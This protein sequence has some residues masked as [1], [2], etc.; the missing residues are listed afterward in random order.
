MVWVCYEGN[1]ARPKP[2][3]FHIWPIGWTIS[4]PY[5]VHICPILFGFLEYLQILFIFLEK[6]NI[7]HLIWVK[8][9]ESTSYYT[10][11]KV[12]FYYNNR[13]IHT[14]MNVTIFKIIKYTVHQAVYFIDLKIYNN[15]IHGG[16]TFCRKTLCRKT[17]CRTDILPTDVLPNGRFAERTF[18]LT[19][20]LPNGQ[21]AERTTCR[22]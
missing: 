21:F 19:D 14:I 18:C 11:S 3:N 16:R 4:I 15:A 5:L 8:E 22:K 2:Y 9:L 13:I 12:V 1:Q 17:F 6:F 10:K 7:V 20:S